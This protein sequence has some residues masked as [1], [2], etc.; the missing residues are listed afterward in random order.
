MK[1]GDLVMVKTKYEGK[2][3]AVIISQHFSS[4]GVEWKVKQLN[5][6]YMT[7]CQSCDLEVISA[8]R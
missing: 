2:K 6:N 1:V 7:L 8:G 5:I 3:P 4:A